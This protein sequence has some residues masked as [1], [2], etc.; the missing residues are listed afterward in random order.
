[1]R[2]AQ[3]SRL[4][5]QP[6]LST[7]VLQIVHSSMS[8]NIGAVAIADEL[9][10]PASFMQ[11]WLRHFPRQQLLFL[12]YEDYIADIPQHLAA[13]LQFLDVS[14]PDS[15]LWAA[16]TTAEAQNRKQYAPMRP[17]TRR[18]LEDFYKPFN[19]AL[20]QQLDA[21]CRWLWADAKQ[22]AAQAG[23]LQ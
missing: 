10:S 18:M 1:M 4:C 12:R 17:D 5:P 6:S 8:S 20:A 3:E 14:Q 21:D 15:S 23:H 16:M 2:Q 22:T 13:V 9:T 11:D 7:A 19:A